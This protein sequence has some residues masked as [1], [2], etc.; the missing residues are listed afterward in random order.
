MRALFLPAPLVFEEA[1]PAFC[2]VVDVESVYVLED[3]RRPEIPRDVGEPVRPSSI[4]TVTLEPAD[5]RGVP[6]GPEPPS[7]R[8]AW[9][10]AGIYRLTV[11]GEPDRQRGEPILHE[12]RVPAYRFAGYRLA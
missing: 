5:L 1:P 10:Y 6:R 4:L 7:Y 3:G 12:A 8:E 2:G 9:N 11:L